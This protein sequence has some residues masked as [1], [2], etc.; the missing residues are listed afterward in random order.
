MEQTL[1]EQERFR[2]ISFEVI[3]T[4]L[5]LTIT[6]YIQRASPRFGPDDSGDVAY[7]VIEVTSFPPL[8]CL[9]DSQ[10]FPLV[11]MT[12]RFRQSCSV[13]VE[14]AVI[15]ND[16]FD[17]FN[18]VSDS[19]DWAVLLQVSAVDRFTGAPVADEIGHAYVRVV[20]DP[21]PEPA[22]AALVSSG[23]VGLSLLYRRRG[24]KGSVR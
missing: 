9:S 3:N 16:P 17:T 20:D 11:G 15:D 1:S 5:P 23:V 14:F 7:D 2:F 8:Q 4:G 6:G 13:A 24:R 10:V 19:A 22:T 18:P 12:L 21:V